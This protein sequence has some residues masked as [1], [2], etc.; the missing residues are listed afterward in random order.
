MKSPRTP[1]SGTCPR[2]NPLPATR[3]C[4]ALTDKMAHKFP[5]D[6]RL[7]RYLTKNKRQ[8]SDASLQVRVD[9]DWAGD[10]PGR[11]STA[12]VIVRGGKHFLRHMS[13]L[14]TRVA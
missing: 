9:S 13:C 3:E 2:F 10:L 4:A 7:G 11:K 6:W 12:V 14:Q 1:R 8:T 5:G